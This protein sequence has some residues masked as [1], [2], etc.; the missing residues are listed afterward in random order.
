MIELLNV[1]FVVSINKES[2]L[3]VEIV[4]CF[5]Y[6]DLLTLLDLTNICLRIFDV[7][8]IHL[9]KEFLLIF[10]S[11]L[12]VMLMKLRVNG[13]DFLPSIIL[14]AWTTISSFINSISETYNT[15]KLYFIAD[16]ILLPLFIL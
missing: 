2:Y 1:E 5:I 9:C 13:V 11:L 4:G 12:S 3:I 15:L 8:S 14:A 6:A 16:I 7:C 10:F